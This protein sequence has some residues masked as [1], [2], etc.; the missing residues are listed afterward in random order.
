RLKPKFLHLE[1]YPETRTEYP[2]FRKSFSH[3]DYLVRVILL[4]PRTVDFESIYFTSNKG[5]SV[6][7]YSTFHKPFSPREVADRQVLAMEGRTRKWGHGSNL[8]Y[9]TFHKPFSHELVIFTRVIFLKRWAVDLKQG[10]V[11]PRRA[12]TILTNKLARRPRLHAMEDR[13]RKCGRET[14]LEFWYT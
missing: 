10:T 5:P 1:S 4:T 2:T 9:S 13:T 14:N 12:T 3:F 6:F 8:E 7:E 11:S